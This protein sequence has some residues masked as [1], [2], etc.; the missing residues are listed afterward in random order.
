MTNTFQGKTARSDGDLAK[1]VL[2]SGLSAGIADMQTNLLLLASQQIQT[3]SGRDAFFMQ[4]Q[5]KDLNSL[6]N[7]QDLED[8]NREI[9]QRG[10]LVDHVYRAY[11]WTQEEGL[12]RRVEHQFKARRFEAISYLGRTC[13]LSFGVEIIG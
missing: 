2:D 5:G 3:T 13:R 8:L 9:S 10:V 11:N 4:T 7:P 1:Y 12:W 6:W